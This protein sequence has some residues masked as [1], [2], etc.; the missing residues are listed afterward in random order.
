MSSILLRLTALYAEAK[1]ATTR[2]EAAQAAGGAP[3]LAAAAEMDAS[4]IASINKGLSDA[5]SGHL[6]S[7]PKGGKQEKLMRDLK[8]CFYR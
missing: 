7:M 2:L 6:R 1:Q 5:L 8:V 3:A 4:A